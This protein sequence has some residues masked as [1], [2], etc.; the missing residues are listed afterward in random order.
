MTGDEKL[1]NMDIGFET[2]LK[3]KYVQVQFRGTFDADAMLQMFERAFQLA[4]SEGRSAVLVDVR[5][6]T[7]EFSTMDRFSV[8]A[9]IAELQQGIFRGIAFAA[10]GNEPLVDPQRFA[11]TVGRNRGADARVFTDIDE[12]VDWVEKKSSDVGAR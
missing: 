4:A 5:D 10:V 1:R 8:G 3:S 11:E 9:H 2:E 6:M 7:G 12:A